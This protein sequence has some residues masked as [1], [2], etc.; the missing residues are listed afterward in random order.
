M[1]VLFGFYLG[2][3]WARFDYYVGIHCL[4]HMLCVIWRLC[5][6]YAGSSWVLFRLC[7]ASIWVLVGS[8]RVLFGLHSGSIAY[9]LGSMLVLCW[10]LLFC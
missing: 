10:V 6:F 1:C 8:M 5:G 7:L 9:Y 2:F 3:I 4:W